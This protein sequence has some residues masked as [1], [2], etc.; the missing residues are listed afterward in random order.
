MWVDAGL[1]GAAFV[2]TI[3][4]GVSVC[5]LRRRVTSG[6]YACPKIALIVTALLWGVLGVLLCLHRGAASIP[7]VFV[8][9][10]YLMGAVGEVASVIALRQHSTDTLAALGLRAGILAIPLV[11]MLFAAASI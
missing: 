11:L 3:A 6:C 10:V 5:T 1:I 2:L 4:L 9:V 7:A 8:A